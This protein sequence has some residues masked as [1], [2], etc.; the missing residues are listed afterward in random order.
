MCGSEFDPMKLV[1]VFHPFHQSRT[2]VDLAV[3]IYPRAQMATTNM[4]INPTFGGEFC[5]NLR[6]ISNV[7]LKTF[8]KYVLSWVA[9][10]CGWN[11]DDGGRAKGRRANSLAA[12]KVIQSRLRAMTAL[13]SKVLA[14]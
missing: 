1:Q 11:C 8:L 9:E 14:G 4:D 3:L 5:F 10:Q 2:L 12:M 6:Q 7:L 13:S